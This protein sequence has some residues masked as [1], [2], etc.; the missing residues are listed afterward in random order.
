MI[1]LNRKEV[2][3]SME[4]INKRFKQL[5][6]TLGMSQ[7]EFGKILGIKKSGVCD[8]E[9]GRNNVSDRHII[10]LKNWNEKN[11]N[12]EWLRYGSGE[13]F[14]PFDTIL[15]ELSF[16]DDEFIKD[17]LEVYISLDKSCRDALKELMYKM[18]EKHNNKKK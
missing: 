7:E 16:G 12:E 2:Y 11:I 6:K 17:F 3:D 14:K 15:A 5:R 10:M 1:L 18:A 13:M 9:A 4:E 8:I